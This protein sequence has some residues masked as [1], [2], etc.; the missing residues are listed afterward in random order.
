MSDFPGYDPQLPILAELEQDVTRAAESALGPR[1]AAAP[2]GRI[3]RRRRGDRQGSRVVRRALVLVALVLLI[4]ASAL[5]ATGAF[6]GGGSDQAV[7]GPVLEVAHG[8]AGDGYRL[9]LHAH[10]H[11]LCR[12][13]ILPGSATSH[14]QPAPRGAGVDVSSG[15]AGNLRFVFGVAGPTTRSV[16]VHVGPRRLRVKTRPV[17]AAAARAAGV[18]PR[19]RTFLATVAATPGASQP[20]AIVSGHADCS[21][22][23]VPAS[24]CEPH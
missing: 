16:V 8:S 10:G 6:D 23:T 20:P 12:V 19:L 21:L 11:S 5:A 2:Q 22:T 17:D 13:L 24:A 7:E 9:L 1:P 3:R 4:G 14:C 18:D 15:L